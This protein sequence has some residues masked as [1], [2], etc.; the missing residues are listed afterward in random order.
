MT[1]NVGARDMFKEKLG[2]VGESSKV[3][4]DESINHYFSPEFRN[5]LD[6]IIQFDKL[7]ET[8]AL[9]IVDKFIFE[10]E[11]IFTEKN[12]TLEISQKAKKYLFEIGFSPTNG[13][14]PMA[15][16]IKNNIKLPLAN[17]ILDGKLKF[18]GHIKIDFESSKN[19]LKIDIKP[20]KM[21]KNKI[22]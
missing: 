22:N 9:K 14:R 2:F 11:T 8:N 1:S 5:R 7:N 15:N 13:A 21:K 16:V 3:D 19:K 17:Q 10:L 12:L 18:G 4:I 20:N 6:A